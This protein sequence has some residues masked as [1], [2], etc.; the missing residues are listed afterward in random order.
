M[1]RMDKYKKIH[2]ESQ[3]D[4]K[5]PL[6]FRREMKKDPKAAS[7][8]ARYEDPVY[9]Q[10]KE[11]FREPEEEFYYED[12][13]QEPKKKQFGFKLPSIK[14]PFKRK[15]KNP[16]EPKPKKKRRW[17]RTLVMILIAILGYSVISFGIG[18]F[19]AKHDS[20]MPKIETQE[21][22]GVKSENGKRNILLLGSD[23][24]DNISGRSDSMMVLQVDGFGKPKLVS[25]MRDM[26]VNIPGV[27]Q[28]K[29]NAAYA[30]GGADLVRQTLKENF[31]IDCR[32]YAM[33]D[34]QTFEKGVDALFPRGVQIDAEKDMSSYI[35]A[36]ISKG[37]QRMNGHTLL[38]Y[39]R[40]RMD[41]EGDFGRV[42]RQQQV[43]QSVFGQLI[44]PLVLLRGPYAAGK[45]WGYLSTDMPNTY[46]V[47]HLLNFAKAVGGIDRLTLPVDGSWSYID[48]D[49]A[50]SAL[51]VDTNQNA[52][53][54]QGFLGK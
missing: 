24:R 30:Y 46:V 20:S 38:N 17:R 14:N 53:S 54:A 29:L 51:A 28:N 25:F 49:N 37:P 44:N 8:K 43:M 23:T 11:P 19:A 36:P 1:S 2:E 16:Y 39:A 48:T 41:E 7:E 12:H 5:K 45:I 47:S 4:E 13:Y 42:R 21:F 27:G 33:V 35:D 15:P 26:Y 52:Q 22:N 50:G 10:P 31:G 34:F 6:G 32:Y 3:K 18:N 40:F 9:E